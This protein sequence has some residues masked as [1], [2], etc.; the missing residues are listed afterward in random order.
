MNANEIAY[1]KGDINQF[2]FCD[3]YGGVMLMR[4]GE[5]EDMEREKRQSRFGVE[6]VPLYFIG[7][8][9]L[10]V[11]KIKIVHHLDRLWTLEISFN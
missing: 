1:K 10:V 8:Y 2:G 9:Q 11:K 3:W 5:D 7:P 4:K 6:G